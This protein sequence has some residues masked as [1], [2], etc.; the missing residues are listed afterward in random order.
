MAPMFTENI[1]WVV[2]TID[3]MELDVLRCYGFTDTMEGQQCVSF[4]E[5]SM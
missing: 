5:L 1:G 3:E 2:L 4:I